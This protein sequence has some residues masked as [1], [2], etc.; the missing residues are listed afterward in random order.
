MYTGDLLKR[1]EERAAIKIQYSSPKLFA[2]TGHSNLFVL[3][4]RCTREILHKLTCKAQGGTDI[5]TIIMKMWGKKENKR[6]GGE[7]SRN[8]QSLP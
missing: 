7:Q 6:E 2:L 8:L 3:Y 4:C 1:L 5:R